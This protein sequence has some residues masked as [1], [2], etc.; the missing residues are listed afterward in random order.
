[1]TSTRITATLF[2]LAFTAALPFALA[3][4]AA[5]AA[6]SAKEVAT[7]TFHAGLA[8]GSKD[9]KTVQSHLHHVVNCL[10]GPKGTGFDANELNPCKD[11]GDGAL[12][13][14]MDA[15]HKKTLQG[16]LDY[17]M[18]GLKTMDLASAQK[19]ATEAQDELKKVK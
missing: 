8:A 19:A 10:V 18:A 1:M 2:G 11:Q 4:G 12:M 6:D 13:D 3:P 5:A 15:A 14:T 9:L 16:A 7:A 17:A